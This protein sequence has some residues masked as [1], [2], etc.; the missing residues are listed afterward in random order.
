MLEGLKEILR[1]IFGPPVCPICGGR[2]CKYIPNNRCVKCDMKVID[3]EAEWLS[4]NRDL[5]RRNPDGSSTFTYV[6][7]FK[8]HK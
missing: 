6:G 1:I 7:D 2:G 4:E 5:F 3:C 8:I